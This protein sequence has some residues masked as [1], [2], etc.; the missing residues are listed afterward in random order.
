MTTINVN[1]LTLPQL[2]EWVAKGLGGEVKLH[3]MARNHYIEF[4]DGLFGNP[5]RNDW[6]PTTSWSQ[7]GPIIDKYNIFIYHYFDSKEASIVNDDNPERSHRCYGK[8]ILIAA[9]R[10]FVAWKF[11]EEI[12]VDESH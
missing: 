2:D 1:D 4:P 7:M 10:A 5:W 6:H 9:A 3:T 8:T 11:G 12:E